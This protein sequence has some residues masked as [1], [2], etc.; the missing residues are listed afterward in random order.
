MEY[1]VIVGFIIFRGGDHMRIIFVIL[2]IFS[3]IVYPNDTKGQLLTY[4]SESPLFKGDLNAFVMNH[5][6]YPLSAQKD[7]IEGRVFV[8]FMIDTL[9]NTLGH[10][11]VRGIREDLNQEAL[12]VARL[13]KFDAPAQ[14]KDKPIEIRFVIPV[15]FSLKYDQIMRNNT[16]C[17]SL[18]SKTDSLVLRKSSRRIVDRMCKKIYFY[19]ND[20]LLYFPIILLVNENRKPHSVQIELANELDSNVVK[21]LIEECMKLEFVSTKK[22]GINVNGCYTLIFRYDKKQERWFYPD[23]LYF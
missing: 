7:S 4:V 20:N 6:Q 17:D 12:R 14:Q 2:F 21:Y 15:D 3:Q 22:S 16:I 19:R 23:M 9:G 18:D 11:V 10:V 13:I 8:S 5:I 1:Y